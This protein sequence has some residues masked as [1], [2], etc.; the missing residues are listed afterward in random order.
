VH[1]VTSEWMQPD[2]YPPV[3]RAGEKSFAGKF[4]P[5][6]YEMSDRYDYLFKGT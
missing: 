2:W 5:A 4:L 6:T 1:I 3:Y